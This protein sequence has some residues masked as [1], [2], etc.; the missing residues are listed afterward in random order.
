MPNFHQNTSETDKCELFILA[1]LGKLVYSTN[2][3]LPP[4]TPSTQQSVSISWSGALLM[5]YIFF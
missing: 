2:K 4:L 1:D 5:I 3:C